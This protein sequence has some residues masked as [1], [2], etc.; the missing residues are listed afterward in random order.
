MS[1][2]VTEETSPDSVADLKLGDARTDG[3]DDANAFVA[4]HR[5]EMNGMDVGAAETGVGDLNENFVGTEGWE[6]VGD[7]LDGAIDALVAGGVGGKSHCIWI[8]EGREK[9]CSSVAGW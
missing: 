5:V 4:E 1:T 2:G 7:L 9:L 8:V 6:G 3:L